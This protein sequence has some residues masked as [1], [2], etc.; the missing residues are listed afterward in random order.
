MMLP[1]WTGFRS[2]GKSASSQ[3]QQRAVRRREMLEM[4]P[5]RNPKLEWREEDD[6]VVL[7][8]RRAQTWKTRLIGAFV[9][10]PAERNIVLDA[11]GADVWKMLDGQTTVQQIVRALARKYQLSAREAEISLQ[12][13]FRELGRRGY[14]VFMTAP[15]VKNPDDKKRRIR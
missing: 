13:F 8:I 9:P 14:V 5:L 6:T 2:G 4:R 12:Q 3:A 15:D 11:I 7:Q 1:K 10:V